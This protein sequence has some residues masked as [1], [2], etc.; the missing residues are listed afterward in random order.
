MSTNPSPIHPVLTAT[1][2]AQARSLQR[3]YPLA[4]C[5]VLPKNRTGVT[6]LAFIDETACDILLSRSTKLSRVVVRFSVDDH[7][8][9]I[10]HVFVQFSG[11]N[12]LEGGF[13]S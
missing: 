13:Q 3:G 8:N 7:T 1:P 9:A 10:R 12:P 5:F 11:E 6:E 4:E 2:A